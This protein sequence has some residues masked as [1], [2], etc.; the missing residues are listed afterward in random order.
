MSPMITILE[1]RLCASHGKPPTSVMSC[2]ERVVWEISRP[3]SCRSLATGN[4]R[5]RRSSV[6]QLSHAH[7]SV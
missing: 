5:A 3:R 7:N 6:M 1:R 2:V 4:A